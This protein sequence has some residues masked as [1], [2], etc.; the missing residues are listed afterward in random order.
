VLYLTSN[1][2]EKNIIRKTYIN[3]PGFQ[4]ARANQPLPDGTIIIVVISAA[5]LDAGGKPV[6]AKDGSWVADK[7][8]AYS[9]MEARAGWGNDIP[10]LLRN[11]NWNYTLFTPGKAP[12]ADGNQAMCLAC[13]KPQ[14]AVSYLFTSNELQDKATTR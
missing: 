6:I 5:R 14:A 9:A 2:A 3:A 13:H 7:I 12:V 11:A 4:A 1:I 8:T 10:E